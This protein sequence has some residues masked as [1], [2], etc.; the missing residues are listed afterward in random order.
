M[1]L[2]PIFVHFPIAFFIL[3]GAMEIFK[4]PIFIRQTWW[5]YTKAVLV[6]AGSLGSVVAL[7][8]GNLAAEKFRGSA[9]LPLLETHETFAVA[10][11]VIFG[12][13]A[14]CYLLVWIKKEK[15]FVIPWLGSNVVFKTVVWI[16]GSPVSWILA[17]VGLI[18]VTITGGLGGML[19]YG[20]SADPAF[21]WFY[22]TFLK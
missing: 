12:F 8:T 14:V 4:F 2:H 19:V 21:A 22:N 13:L 3:Y 1:D 16:V 6:V 5:F 17:L 18:C 20:P 15:E 9:R 10:T 11:A 7:V